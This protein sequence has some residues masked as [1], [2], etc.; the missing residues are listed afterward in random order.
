MD[1]ILGKIENNLKSNFRKIEEFPEYLDE[2][3]REIG[4]KISEYK[5]IIIGSAISASP[6]Y[7]K[8]PI[9]TGLQIKNLYEGTRG[10]L[11]GYGLIIGGVTAAVGLGIMFGLNAIHSLPSNNEHIQYV[12]SQ[13]GYEAFAPQNTINYDGHTD[14]EGELILNNGTTIHNVIWD[15]RYAGTI[16]KN[17]NQIDQLNNQFV[18]Q[19]DPIKNQPYKPLLDVYIIKGPVPVENVTING[20]TY[21]VIEA[22]NIN[23][24]NIA[25]FYTYQG[26]VP[27]F[28]TAMNTP[29]AYAAVIPGNS[30]VYDWTNTT[31]TLVY[32]TH[33][34]QDYIR[35]FSGGDVLVQPNGTIIPYGINNNI[36]VSA[37]F[38]NFVVPPQVYNSSS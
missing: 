7:V 14:P 32:E 3:L 24:A 16:I 1:G 34:Y 31:G 29:E 30:P 13:N 27:N 25:G 28:V 5:P 10:K 12:G 9:L 37:Y 22:N 8:A 26:W 18:G 19:T 20:Q 35:G 6:L 4:N 33:L 23:P 15:G 17:D 2:R 11:L 36:P 21:Y 38:S